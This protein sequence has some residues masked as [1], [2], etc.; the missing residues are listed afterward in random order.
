MEDNNDLK[1]EIKKIGKLEGGRFQNM[2]NQILDEMGYRIHPLGS[3]DESDKT[4]PGTP[5]TFFL[6]DDCYTLV[7][8]TTQEDG[9]FQ[10]IKDD[11]VKC[12]NKIRDCKIEKGKIIEFYTSSNL[13]IEQFKELNDLCLSDNI[14]LEIYNIDMI[15]NLL[16]K[17]YPLIAKEY[18]GIAVD[19]LQV[20]SPIEYMKEYNMKK[21]SVKINNELL[22]RDDEKK[23]ILQNIADN[24]IV[25]ISGKSGCGKTHLILDI[26][27]NDK[28]QLNE[29]KILCI[30][31]RNQNLFDD[32]KKYLKKDNK[33][34][35][36]IDDINNI[37][38]IGQILYF[39]NPIN[40]LELKI[41][42]TV[43]D[44]AKSRVI[45]KI[46]MEENET[47]NYFKIGYINIKQLTD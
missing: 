45:E 18:L 35:I 13:K 41:V 16:R 3:H 15:A 12:I 42:A 30:K 37:N 44:Y 33:Y 11:V 46:K 1:I 34:I 19:T 17:E 2:C 27:I 21:G 25:L 40:N 20:L 28:S 43:R 23:E 47:D 39:L 32:L 31:N 4:T 6:K 24:D 36:F 5:D 38:D 7:E 8:Y 14:M 26:M 9:I 10:K 22:Y 29:Y